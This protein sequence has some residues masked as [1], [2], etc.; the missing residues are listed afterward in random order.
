MCVLKADISTVP[1][2]RADC[3]KLE[4]EEDGLC[5]GKVLVGVMYIRRLCGATTS[6]G[7]G[8]LEQ[9]THEPLPPGGLAV[10]C[11]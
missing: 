5:L 3:R 6:L 7:A 4:K 9:G 2:G 8:A 11:K 10:C 1:R